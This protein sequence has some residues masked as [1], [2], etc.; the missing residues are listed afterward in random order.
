MTPPLTAIPYAVSH[1]GCVLVIGCRLRTFKPV[2]RAATDVVAKD[3]TVS[4]QCGNC[5]QITEMF[6]V[7]TAT[8]S[9]FKACGHH[10]WVSC[11][12]RM[13]FVSSNQDGHN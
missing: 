12:D 4:S 5:P 6:V 11:V 9:L 13:W 2:E 1:C 10:R 7:T 3:V 8:L